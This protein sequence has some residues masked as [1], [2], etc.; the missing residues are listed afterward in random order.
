MQKGLDVFLTRF[1]GAER[2]R[3]EASISH[4]GFPGEAAASAPD[5]ADPWPSPHTALL[6]QEGLAARGSVN[7]HIV[8]QHTGEAPKDIHGPGKHGMREQSVNSTGQNKNKCLKLHEILQQKKEEK[9]NIVQ[10]SNN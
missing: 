5:A 7:K 8:E 2:G 4:A 9:K 3:V 10:Q 1:R 6:C